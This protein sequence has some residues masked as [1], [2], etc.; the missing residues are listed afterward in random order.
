MRNIII[1][2]VIS[3]LFSSCSKN[4]ESLNTN[5]KDATQADA[6]AF[7]AYAVKWTSDAMQT[8][9]YG[10]TGDPFSISRFL[11]Q[12]VSCNTYTDGTNYFT[13]F[14]WSSW[15]SN[16]VNNLA[17]A[18]TVVAATAPIDQAGTIQKKNRTA[19]IEIMN[20]YAY[21]KLVEAFG[22]IPY[23]DAGNINNL[24]P[25]YDDANTIYTD[26]FKRLY[27]AIDSLNTTGT[28]FGSYDLVYGDKIAQWKKFANSLLLQMGLRIMD[29]NPTLGAKA[30]QDAVAGGVFTGNGDN[31]QLVYLNAQPNTNP[32]W[33]SL[34]VGNRQDF[35]AAAPY[36]DALNSLNDPRRAVY[37]TT[38]NGNYVGAPYGQPSDY[39][40]FSHFGALFYTPVLP[41]ILLDDASVEFFLAEA[42][43]RG[44]LGSPA[45]A[46][47]HYNAAIRASFAYYSVT[48]VD[49]YLTQPSVAYTTAAGDWK[50]KIGMQ[51]W[52]ALFNQGP[53]AWTEYRRLDW[54]KLT[55]PKNAFVNIVPVRLLYPSTEQTL[56]GAN[57]KAASTAIGGDLMTT[58][59]FWDKF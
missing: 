54:P 22:N 4:L 14:T 29:A 3:L 11:T 28:G 35:I 34:A 8:I 37:F 25:K 59:L 31:A 58:K 48:G 42:A 53:E 18:K 55:A 52:L 21:S 44:I 51:K 57:W 15:Y 26:L 45:D 46:E 20:V 7:F 5:T 40:S 12:Q 27:S 39:N 41:G 33:V 19:L 36:V 30:V 10:T 32:L 16:V 1:I 24:S 9:T 49:A 17:A 43:E 23:T 47:S 13:Q 50:Q 2:F 38:V 56:N 6:G